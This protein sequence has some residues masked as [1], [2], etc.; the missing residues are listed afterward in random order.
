MRFVL[1]MFSG[2]H[3]HAVISHFNFSDAPVVETEQTYIHTTEN[4]ETEVICIVHAS[5]KA[6]V[7]W[8]KNGK[9]LAKEDGIFTERGSRHSLILPAFKKNFGVYTCKATNEFGSD[10]KR[11]E[12]SGNQVN[13]SC[14]VGKICT[15]TLIEYIS[16]DLF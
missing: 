4:D 3:D 7:S 16:L 10:E 15:F 6:G 13:L 14:T 12:V 9:K 8:Y 11:T 5:P 2:L 1:N